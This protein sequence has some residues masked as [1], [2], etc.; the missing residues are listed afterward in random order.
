[1]DWC[2]PLAGLL[3]VGCQVGLEVRVCWESIGSVLPI[4]LSLWLHLWWS[5]RSCLSLVLRGHCFSLTVFLWSHTASS[6]LFCQLLF[7]LL[8]WG[9]VWISS[10]PLWCFSRPVGS[11]SSTGPVDLA[12]VA[13]LGSGWCRSLAV[14][15]LWW[16]SRH[17]LTA[18]LCVV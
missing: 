14:S 9:R 13:G 8:L 6:C 18:T 10:C 2:S 3:L 11:A 15:S 16:G 17:W 4:L 7:L 5:R 12:S 1:M